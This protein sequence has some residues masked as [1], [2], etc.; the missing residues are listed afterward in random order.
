MYTE[1]FTETIWLEHLRHFIEILDSSWARPDPLL[2][3]VALFYVCYALPRFDSSLSS[4][5]IPFLLARRAV[6]TAV[7]AMIVASVLLLFSAG[8][9]RQGAAG[10][11]TFEQVANDSHRAPSRIEVRVLLVEVR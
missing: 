9:R 8:D 2:C 10:E 11:Y 1:E 5:L 7:R 4:V 6:P 3:C